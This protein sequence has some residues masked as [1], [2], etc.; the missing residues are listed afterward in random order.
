MQLELDL[1][2]EIT[3]LTQARAKLEKDINDAR[4]KIEVSLKREEANEKE[5]ETLETENQDLLKELQNVAQEVLE[6]LEAHRQELAGR[7]DRRRSLSDSVLSSLEGGKKLLAEARAA[8]SGKD[9]ARGAKLLEELDLDGPL[10][11]F[12]EYENLEQGVRSFLFGKTGLLAG[13][14]ELDLKMEKS[15]NRREQLRRETTALI[16]ERRGLSRETEK[17]NNRVVELEL[18]IR[19]SQVR[20]ESSLE[21]RGDIE[22]QSRETQDRINYYNKEVVQVAEQ[23]GKRD[24]DMEKSALLLAELKE[25]HALQ[26]SDISRIKNETEE[27]RR[28]VN[29]MREKSR[30]NRDEFEKLLPAISEQERKAESVNVARE[31]LEE[32]LYN[33]FQLSAH[34]LQEECSG[35]SLEKAREEQA[36]KKLKESIKSLGQFNPLAIEE[37]GRTQEAYDEITSQLKD[38]EDARDNIMKILGEIDLKSRELFLDTFER[39]RNN[40]SEVF[41]ALFGGG[42]ASLTLLDEADPLN[43]GVDI[44]VQ[45]PGKKNTSLSLLSGGEQ[46]MTAIALMFATYLVRPSPFCFLDEID[47]P[48]DDNNV[49]RFLRMLSGFSTRS[50]FLVITHNKL[51]M[52][53]AGGLFGVTQEEPGVSKLVS[54]QLRERENALTPG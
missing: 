36:H 23:R 29:D 34:E 41:Q 16:E 46:N 22:T 2:T 20:R 53:K 9:A 49:N 6:E 31:V 54:V 39:I 15:R 11:A 47:A 32:D 50:Q 1:D 28:R 8:L 38:V 26:E 51:T 18:R 10:G 24:A 44:M 37:L 4:A 27:A 25:K 48:L 5:L 19:D 13:K 17:N 45:P 52:G 21:V 3:S 35:R 7:E 30:N 12:R 40:F 43:S 33:D 14:R 42:K